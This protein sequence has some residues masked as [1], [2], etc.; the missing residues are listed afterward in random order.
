MTTRWS[1]TEMLSV[2]AAAW[3]RRVSSTSAPDGVG[4]P[5]GWLWS[6]MIEAAPTSSARRGLVDRAAG[7]AFVQDQAVPLV[8]EQDTELLH[9]PPAHAGAAIGGER[10]VVVQHLAGDRG[11]A[12]KLDPE[13]LGDLDERDGRLPYILDLQQRR[14]LGGQHARQRAEGLD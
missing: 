2:F 1:N 10:V 3:M 7:L 12:G 14:R 9:R 8:Q 11:L 5:L 6:R 4:S 13:R